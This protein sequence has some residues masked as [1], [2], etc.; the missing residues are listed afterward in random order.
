ME[1][2]EYILEQIKNNDYRSLMFTIYNFVDE[3]GWLI[4]HKP[5]DGGTYDI[6]DLC[7]AKINFEE[8]NE[9][10]RLFTRTDLMKIGELKHIVERETNGNVGLFVMKD[11]GHLIA[12]KPNDYDVTQIE[13]KF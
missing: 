9:E 3:S 4:E 12:V 6:D 1:N 8:D 2:F 11:I 5:K 10:S 13:F 7:Y